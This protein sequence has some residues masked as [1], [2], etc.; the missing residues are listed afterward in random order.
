M[1]GP[2]LP[3]GMAHHSFTS[4]DPIRTPRPFP[5]SRRGQ[6]AGVDT[7]AG[8][9]LRWFRALVLGTVVLGFGSIAHAAA[10]GHLPGAPAL[11]A[12]GAL[13][14][15]VSATLLDRPAGTVLMVVLTVVG[16]AL[17]HAWLT[18]T[19]GHSGQHG[20]AADPLGHLLADLSPG[21]APMMLAH[22]LAALSVGLWLAAGER[23]LWG[24]LAILGAALVALVRHLLAVPPGPHRSR[25][26]AG[27]VD[28]VR[29]ALRMLVRS[30]VRRG[31][32]ALLTA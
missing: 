11:V 28:E 5:L 30:V 25:V 3:P 17:V 32:P 14:I 7:E 10:G 1:L 23:A 22:T 16:Q 8:T 6:N 13:S 18:L 19:V 20:D 29:P 9:V 26:P 15:L 24:V 4:V 12:A 21:N 27:P 2:C 31:P